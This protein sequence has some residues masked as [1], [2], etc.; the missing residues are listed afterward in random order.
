[1]VPSFKGPEVRKTKSV[2]LKTF[3]AP[4]RFGGTIVL[5][6]RSG[7]EDKISKAGGQFSKC[8]LNALLTP[9]MLYIMTMNQILEVTEEPIDVSR[10][11]IIRLKNMVYRQYQDECGPDY[12]SPQAHMLLGKLEAIDQILDMD[13]Q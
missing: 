7:S 12:N 11:A 1:M 13:G 5:L 3:A 8:P 2:S 6:G 9:G 4:R 10:K